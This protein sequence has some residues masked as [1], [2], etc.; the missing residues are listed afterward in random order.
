MKNA[1]KLTAVILIIVLVFTLIGNA[2]AGSII[3]TL[4]NGLK[5]AWNGVKTAG[6]AV[7]DTVEYVCTDKSAA[8]AYGDTV[9]AARNT[10]KAAYDTADAAK[11]IPKD[12]MDVA[13]GAKK[14]VAGA[15]ELVRYGSLEDAY[16]YITGDGPVDGATKR[17]M[18]LMKNGYKQMDNGLILDV[19]K[20]VPVYG[21]VIA[22]GADAV[23]TGAEYALGYIDAEQAVNN[24]IKDT[25][26]TVVG[27]ATAGAGELVEGVA[28]GI[29]VKV[30]GIATKE[31]LKELVD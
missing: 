6:N 12:A 10:Q 19:V 28:A 18:D 15:A 20:L 29:G 11:Q 23:K 30:A 4:K 27:T 7:C 13:E 21:T 8:E 3:D 16:N 24:L 26:D 2:L 25:I 9:N 5:T 1:R 17:A 14:V 31:G 22:A